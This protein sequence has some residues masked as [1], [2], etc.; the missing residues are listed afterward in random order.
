MVV[1]TR[2]KA[3]AVAATGIRCRC[4]CWRDRWR[5]VWLVVHE[6]SAGGLRDVFTTLLFFIRC[7]TGFDSVLFEQCGELFGR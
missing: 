2:G 7:T 6:A 1:T 4:G 5:R 3:A